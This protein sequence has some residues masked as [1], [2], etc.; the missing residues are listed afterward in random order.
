QPRVRPFHIKPLPEPRGVLL[1]VVP[2]VV[3]G[4]DRLPPLAVLAVPVDRLLEPTRVERVLRRPAQVAQLGRVDRVAAVVAGPVRD[5]A[6]EIRA[7]ARQVEDAANDLH[8]LAL[9]P[10]DVVD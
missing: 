4:F 7:G 8:V 6:Y 1:L 5:M 10:A 2:L 9:L 3:A